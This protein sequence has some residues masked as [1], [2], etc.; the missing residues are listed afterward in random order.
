[1]PSFRVGAHE[2][3]L[4]RNSIT[5][6]FRNFEILFALKPAS[7]RGEG[8][9]VKGT[10]CDLILRRRKNGVSGWN[11]GSKQ[12][13]TCDNLRKNNENTTVIFCPLL[14]PL[15]KIPRYNFPTTIIPTKRSRNLL[16]TEKWNIHDYHEQ[17]GQV[18]IQTICTPIA[19]K[20]PH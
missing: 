15:Q 14:C 20:D 13:R 11:S 2:L 18:V 3:V 4:H 17:E 9:G 8:R 16:I 1:M 7:S 10:G 6:S 12:G 5:V 19:H